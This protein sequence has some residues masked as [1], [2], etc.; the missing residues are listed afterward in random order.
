MPPYRNK[1]IHPRVICPGRRHGP[2]EQACPDAISPEQGCAIMTIHTVNTDQN[3]Q[4]SITAD[5]DTWIIGKAATFRVSN[6][7]GIAENGFSGS[8]IKILGDMVIKGDSYAGAHINGSSTS[9]LVG[10]ASVINANQ[11]TFGIFSEAA[12]SEI[13]NRG[14]IAAGETGIYGAIWSDVTNEGT[15]KAQFG[16]DF[17]GEG[18][19]IHNAG[20]I[21]AS[22]IA[23]AIGANN[24]LVVNEK[25]GEI[26]GEQIGIHLEGDGSAVL[27]NKGILRSDGNALQSEGSALTFTNTG[28]IFGDVVLGAGEDVFDTRDGTI[29]GVVRGGADSDTFKIAS[30]GIKIVEAA[31]GGDS[32]R[33]FSTVSYTLGA[34]VDELH[35]K[36]GKDIDGT[37][38]STANFIAGN[39]GDNTLGGRGGN[40]WLQGHAGN[41][42]L[43]GGGGSDT[44]AFEKGWDRDV[45]RDFQDGLDGLFTSEVSNQADFDAL[46]VKQVGE[47]VVIDFG[48]GDRLVIEDMLKANINFSD[49]NIT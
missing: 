28:K 12:G 48:G 26:I 41:D 13:T 42:L 23:I 15:I 46:D 47:N 1:A 17:D 33:V 14:H 25:Q 27:V 45:I 10:A 35:L 11:A 44:F 8:T 38:G 18:G 7:N 4:W 37:G 43:L 22:G 6:G 40:D 2:V 16:I 39:S 34:H 5:D 20:R 24:A 31:N 21:N 9:L 3:S 49:F 36:G 32:D 29:Q 19:I 30:S